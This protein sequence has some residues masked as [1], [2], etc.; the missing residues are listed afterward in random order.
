[1]RRQASQLASENERRNDNECDKKRS[2]GDQRSTGIYSQG[3]EIQVQHGSG[4]TR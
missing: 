3:K 2:V 1:M 4:D